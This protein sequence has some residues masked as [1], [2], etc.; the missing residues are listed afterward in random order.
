MARYTR[1]INCRPCCNLYVL[2]WYRLVC[3]ESPHGDSPAHLASSRSAG[4][5]CHEWW[6]S[7]ASAADATVTFSNETKTKK[8]R[9][10]KKRSFTKFVC[11]RYNEIITLCASLVYFFLFFTQNTLRWLLSDSLETCQ[12]DVLQFRKKHCY[13]DCLKR[14]QNKR[15]KNSQIAPIFVPIRITMSAVISQCEVSWKIKNIILLV[16]DCSSILTQVSRCRTE[17]TE[18]TMRQFR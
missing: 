15:R 17:T 18:R 6:I 2:A 10:E 11:P 4:S 8:W 16:N 14:P 5:E 3:A 7:A 1:V 13:A 9:D 12:H